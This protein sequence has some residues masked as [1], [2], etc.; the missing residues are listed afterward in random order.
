MLFS[1]DGVEP[2]CQKRDF[3]ESCQT[4]LMSKM[5]SART[6]ARPASPSGKQL[7][8]L[9]TRDV[10]VRVS[11]G[12]SKDGKN[13]LDGSSETC[14]TSDN[15]PPN[16]DPSSSDYLL[17]FKLPSAVQLDT[18]HSLALTFAG[19]FCPM[20]LQVLASAED[21]AKEW[22]SISPLLHPRDTNA[23]QYF[24]I[25][26][27]EPSNIGGLRLQFR[28]STDDYGRLTVYEAEIF[29]AQ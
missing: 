9:L 25:S 26:S 1:E 21:N 16:S 11:S 8:N 10:K 19:G 29:A 3:L 12:S 2:R 7:V 13:V 4:T 15:L 5:A 24:A 28:G 27:T 18:L 17:T 22:I 20:S 6:L 23:K 14:W